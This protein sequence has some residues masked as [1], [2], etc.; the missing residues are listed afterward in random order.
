MPTTN[1][2]QRAAAVAPKIAEITGLTTDPL[3]RIG[4]DEQ[5]SRDGRWYNLTDPRALAAV[6]A[7]LP[8]EVCRDALSSTWVRAIEAG[9]PV[10]GWDCVRWLLTP[11]GT[12]SFMESAAVVAL[13][14][15]S[16]A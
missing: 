9:H 4:L 2:D 5:I 16:D 1:P 10:E 14:D 8:P 11:A 7:A 13:E 12:L 15:K 3:A 6:V